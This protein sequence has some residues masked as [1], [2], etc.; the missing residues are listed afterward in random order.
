MP[1]LATY[2]QGS[3]R[4]LSHS[5][6]RENEIKGIQTGKVVI[7]LS[8][9]ADDMIL[10]IENHKDAARK[11]LLLLL[12]LSRFSRV[13]L[14]ATPQTAAH[15]ATPSLGFSRQEHWSGLPLPSP[16]ENY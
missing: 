15:Q 5:N 10:Y 7:K 6:Q 8:L 12:L 1:T 2:I 3:I 13:R 11:L 14:C 16:I 9:F 4:S